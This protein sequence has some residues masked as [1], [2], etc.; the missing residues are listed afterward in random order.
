MIRFVRW[1]ES[2]RWRGAGF[3]GGGVALLIHRLPLQL[4]M[5]ASLLA[6]EE[7]CG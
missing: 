5:S 3:G 4:C 2:Y 6:C 1:R 7:G